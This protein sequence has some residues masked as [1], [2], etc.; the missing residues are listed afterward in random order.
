LSHIAGWW[1]IVR[2]QPFTGVSVAD[3]SDI[4]YGSAC[5]ED[6]LSEPTFVSVM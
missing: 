2:R 6:A 1:R 5:E 4:A 3:V